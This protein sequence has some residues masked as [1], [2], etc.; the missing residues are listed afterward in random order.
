MEKPPLHGRP[1][2][3]S[4]PAKEGVQRLFTLSANDETAAKK[5]MNQLSV[6]LEQHPEVFQKAL[7]RNLAYTLCQRRSHL[8]WRV[9]LVASS[10]SGLAEACSVAETK[11]V[12]AS[13]APK[14]A[15]VYTGQGAQWHAMGRELLETHSVFA[16][17]IRSAD[18][19]LR[20]YGANFSLLEE[21][22]RDKD[23]SQV[24]KAH[25]SQ[26]IC[27][28]VQLGLTDLLKSWRV[29]PSSVTGH[30]S[31]EIGAAYAAG[32]LTHEAAMAIAYHRGQAIVTMRQRYPDLKGSMMAVG[33]SPE[34]ASP[35]VKMLREGTAVIACE[36]SPTSITASGDE[37]AINELAAKVESKQIFNRKL[38]VDVAYHSPHMKLVA[39][40]YRVSIKDVTP[41]TVGADVGFYS[42]LRGKKVDL[43]SLDA[44]Y[45]VD[46]LTCPVR[47]STSVRELCTDSTPD[48]IVEIGPHAALEGP[49]KQVIKAVGQQASKVVY[50]SALRR[51]QNATTTALRLAADL[52]MKGQSLDFTAI[53]LEDPM[54]E[55]PIVI[56]DMMPYPWSR[57]KYWYESRMSQQ[58][59]QKPFPRHDLLGSMTDFSNDLAPTW[60]NI[61][62]TEDIPW[63]RDHKMQFLTTFPFAG[64]VS[65]AV[66]A[67]AQRATMRGMES[68]RFS[69][70][71]IQVKRPLLMEDGAEYEV[72]LS[73]AP[74]AEG[75]RDY[76][77]DWDEFRIWSWEQGKAWV[78][79]CRG[80]IAVRKGDG[81]NPVNL[82]SRFIAGRK[83]KTAERLCQ[84][85]VSTEAFYKELD[86]NGATYGSTF[87]RL[88][89]IKGS[90]D[91][92]IAELDVP[93]TAATMPM[94][95]QTSYIVHPTL[96]DQILQLSFPILGAGRFGMSTLYMPT[97][98]QELQLQRG[99]FLTP[100]S[101][102]H[103]SGHGVHDVKLQKPTEF[104]MEALLNPK[105][106]RSLISLVGL[107]MVPVKSASYTNDAPRELCFKL[108]WEPL[109]KSLDDA[110]APNG[111]DKACDSSSETKTHQSK[112]VS[113]A[114]GTNVKECH[115]NG[116]GVNSAH[117]NGTRVNGTH[118]NGANGVDHVADFPRAEQSGRPASIICD[119]LDAPVARA[120]K[121]RLLDCTG[122]IPGM[123]T[124]ANA[125][126]PEGLYI[127]ICE[128][129]TPILSTLTPERFGQVQKLLT[130]SAGSL[131]VTNGAYLNATNPAGNMAVGLTR[132]I[133]SETAAK[134]A[135]LDLDPEYKLDA[136][137]KA[138]LII[139][140]FTKVFESEGES[141]MEFAEKG[142][143]LVIP[144]ILNDDDM[145]QQVHREVFT[146]AP[147]L[148]N[149]E[150]GSRRLKMAIGT[151][152]ALD[153]LYFRDDE[154]CDLG[155]QE[156]E[157]QVMATGV[158]FK[159]V[160]I[161][162]GQLSSPY[163]GIECAGVVSRIGPGVQSLA[164]GDRVAAMSEGAYGHFT[165]C[166]VTSAARIPADMS[167]E[168]AASIPVVYCTA[169]YGII[170]L[171]QLAEGERVLIHAAA[172]G[173]GQAAMHLA[174]MTGTEIYVTVGSSEKKQ[175]I[176]DNYNIPE[177]HIFSSRDTS[178]GPAIRELTNGAGVDV[179]INSL[180][181]EILRETW[182]C[183]A[184][185]G[186]FIE[187]GKRDINS[188]TQQMVV[189]RVGSLDLVAEF[190]HNHQLSYRSAAL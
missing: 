150:Q 53:N 177:D 124:L 86:S 1:G 98:I 173:V 180:A 148:Q 118:V 132:T 110:S 60:R 17:S 46:N 91:Y 168:M 93:D 51:N 127:V 6:F 142:G 57:Q 121:D 50:F 18:G 35:L 133:R 67:A 11:P 13:Q 83:F 19:C 128:L 81:S 169:Y 104:S 185:F 187:I 29:S 70:R 30:S 59:R 74:Y 139:R 158:N 75:T 89:D 63:L 49:V 94:E 138:E 90:A 62:R 125:P 102:L 69:L 20:R 122:K 174:K 157:I 114:N 2:V 105:D 190:G 145:N 143:A 65:M 154:P 101:K 112:G 15:F 178:F 126:D 151:T 36:N 182:D 61:I 47:F 155:E 45:W 3:P 166:P 21:L 77:D 144:R 40:D 31:G 135:T 160:V 7:L 186:R 175:F 179:I 71:E 165:M 58:H 97:A 120:L 99:A 95:H 117:V 16:D 24:G 149:F 23:T 189:L 146:S 84:E 131:W 152:G 85:K 137:S 28:A 100:G 78:E 52:Y 129:D 33:A 32:A 80:T 9:G 140:T 134:S 14:I 79:H 76:S 153:T 156:I 48:V 172:G 39:D 72:M 96:L 176:M 8:Q 181:G 103:V 22:S 25:I 141:D 87:R 56:S 188:N 163:L 147:Y 171:G 119:N 183:I 136:T 37:A 10:A 4:P 88:R 34:T 111:S 108:Q 68:E 26:P 73:M 64:F 92:S 164:I 123:F 107:L 12:R 82:T 54:V 38:H 43:S 106:E 41:S 170:E 66:E 55:P 109:D 130:R 113:I 159:D 42:S 5:T 116:N 161:A 167:F 162:M 27:T 44:S 184:H 115:V